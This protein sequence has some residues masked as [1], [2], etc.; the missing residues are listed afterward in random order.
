MGKH[1]VKLLPQLNMKTFLTLFACVLA[2]SASGLSN[3]E[4][5]IEIENRILKTALAK[6]GETRLAEWDGVGCDLWEV[7]KCAGTLA[8]TVAA[9][10]LAGADWGLTLAGC[11]GAAIGAGDTCYPCICDVIEWLHMGSC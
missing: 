4:S 1:S 3:P 6:V 10:V 11:I 8:A 2:V 7:T 5:Q 9:C